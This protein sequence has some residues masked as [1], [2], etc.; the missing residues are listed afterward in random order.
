LLLLLLHR[1]YGWIFE[2]NETVNISQLSKKEL[3]NK[4]QATS[5]KQDDRKMDICCN[6]NF[7]QPIVHTVYLQRCCL[8]KRNG[9]TKYSIR[10]ELI[11]RTTTNHTMKEIFFLSV[12]F[13]LFT[14]VVSKCGTNDYY[15]ILE[16][17][18]QATPEEIKKQYRKLA[19]LYHPDKN[20]DNPEAAEAKFIE[21]SKAYEILSDP[22]SRSTYDEELTYGR[23]RGGNNAAS[24]PGRGFHHHGHY[25]TAREA[26]EI[27]RHP[28]QMFDDEPFPG[29]G[30]RQHRQQRGDAR[31]RTFQFSF[32][33]Q[34][35]GR[36]FYTYSTN[37]RQQFQ[38]QQQQ[39][40]Q[41]FY[42]Y[43]DPSTAYQWT[44][45][46]WQVLYMLVTVYIVLW[47]LTSCCIATEEEDVTNRPSP[48]SATNARKS[49][50]TAP[51]TT[52]TATKPH[53]P[54]NSS[55]LPQQYNPL[56]IHLPILG[57]ELSKSQGI[58]FIIALNPKME[59]F[60]LQI[61]KNFLRDP[62]LFRRYDGLHHNNNP[63]PNNQPN[64][65]LDKI[66]QHREKTIALDSLDALAVTK[67]GQQY[68]IFSS[69]AKK[70]ETITST[71]TQEET[72]ATTSL[73]L[74]EITYED[75][76]DNWLCALVQGNVRWKI[77]H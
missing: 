47:F 48:A 10:K 14:F 23:S 32:G 7:L 20:P 16:V 26:D 61:R 35:D 41:Q 29:A 52:T 15:C 67:S 12:I 50:S 9:R 27:F 64:P 28:S 1:H 34:Q 21:L 6:Y 2:K 55:L 18:K 33:Q 71:S 46:V 77:L 30:F 58:I 56:D 76:V 45:F 17:K 44:Y 72:A 36:T 60:C 39:A 19:K 73:P 5:S 38:Q 59:Q 66:L 37:P 69:A 31:A 74:R 53:L 42:Y 3:S 57:E 62:L 51:N 54:P 68:A 13:I 43:Y 8:K 11:K 25:D 75:Q 24:S 22:Q 63:K 40:Q 65:I 49:S 70:K 4:I